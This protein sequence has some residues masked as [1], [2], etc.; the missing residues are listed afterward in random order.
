MLESSDG[1]KEAEPGKGSEVKQ[2]G[3]ESR[4]QVDLAGMRGYHNAREEEVVN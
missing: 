2:Q 1:N 4:H 3:H